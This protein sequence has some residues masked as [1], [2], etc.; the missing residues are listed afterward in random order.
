M[1]ISKMQQGKRTRRKP[2]KA[3]LECNRRKQ[4]VCSTLALLP[5][6]NNE[7]N[8]SVSQCNRQSPCN[9]CVSRGV[10]HMC[11]YSNF[12][13][14]SPGRGRSMYQRD[15]R[16]SSAAEHSRGGDSPSVTSSDGS[17]SNDLA[18]E[19]VEAL[20]Y[21]P[22]PPSQTVSSHSNLA[23]FVA[24]PSPHPLFRDECRKLTT[25]PTEARLTSG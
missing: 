12:H 21:P 24:S 22:A 3:C 18:F 14:K 20:G 1:S 4:K 7:L 23:L 9:H 5:C 19:N 17:I 11:V 8:E 16:S 15:R 10:E 25:V 13:P 6:E 2:I